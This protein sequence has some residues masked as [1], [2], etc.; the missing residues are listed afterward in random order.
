MAGISNMFEG[1]I[2]VLNFYSEAQKPSNYCKIVIL[3]EIFYAIFVFFLSTLA[4][5]AFGP[6][7]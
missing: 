3:V 1:N 5:M 7:T 4:Y 6:L 2:L